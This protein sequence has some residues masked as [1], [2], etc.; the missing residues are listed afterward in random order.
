MSRTRATRQLFEAAWGVPLDAEPGL[1]IPNMLDAATE[2]AFKALFIQGEDILQSTPTPPMSPPGWRRWSAWSCRTCSSTR[3]PITRMSSCRDRPSWR[4]DGTFTNAERRI[5]RVRQVMRPKNGYADWEI[6]QLV[7]RALGLGWAYAH[8]SEI[9]D[10]IARLTPTFAR[11]SYDALDQHGSLQ[12]PATEASPTARPPCT[13]TAS[14]A[15]RALRGDRL[16]PD[17]RE[18]RP[19]LPA[20]ADHGA[21]P[22]PL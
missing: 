21:H 3:P 4:K 9:M 16:Y 5:Q 7:A 18:D 8:P 19:A 11:V 10:E 20:A 1:R 13:W 2:G 22:Q 6:V 17:R 14:C 12:W 15:A